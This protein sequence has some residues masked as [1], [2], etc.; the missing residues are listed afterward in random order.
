MKKKVLQQGEET[1][2]VSCLVISIIQFLSKQYTVQFLG[3]TILHYFLPPLDVI[4]PSVPK[5]VDFD[6]VFIED[7]AYLYNNKKYCILLSCN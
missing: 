3:V 6:P 5:V 2:I 7:Y 4:N 1:V